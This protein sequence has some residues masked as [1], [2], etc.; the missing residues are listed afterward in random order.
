MRPKMKK[1]DMRMVLV[2]LTGDF[3]RPVRPMMPSTG[4]S[5]VVCA[6][7]TCDDVLHFAETVAMPVLGE[8]CQRVNE[9]IKKQ[10][11]SGF[12]CLLT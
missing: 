2:A 4:T 9:Y 11:E 1:I 6:N 3:G 10:R 5:G 8:E 7:W 12:N